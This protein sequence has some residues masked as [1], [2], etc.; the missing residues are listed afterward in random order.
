MNFFIGNRKRRKQ[1]LIWAIAAMALANLAMLIAAVAWPLDAGGATNR[2]SIK[3][4]TTSAPSQN[5][6]DL[7]SYAAIYQRDL[8]TP[9]VEVKAAPPP[10]PPPPKLTITLVGTAIDPDYTCAFFKLANGQ[11]QSVFVGQAIEQAEVVKI[12]EGSVVV[13]YADQDMTLSVDMTGKGAK[14]EAAEPPARPEPASQTAAPKDGQ[15]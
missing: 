8:R 12:M 9:L 4:V 11:T 7:A 10:K 3:A 14:G 5:R 1:L 13:H 2:P 6:E 15:P